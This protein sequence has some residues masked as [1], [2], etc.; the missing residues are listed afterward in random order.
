MKKARWVLLALMLCAL[1]TPG[2]QAVAG[3]NLTAEIGYDGVITYGRSLPLIAV[4]EAGESGIEGFIQVDLYRNGVQYD[5]VEYPIAVAAGAQKRVVLPVTLTMAQDQYEIKLVSG[6]GEALLET[7]F[8]PARALDPNSV[9]LGLLSQQA[10]SLS[11]LNAEA[12]ELT[13]TRGARWQAIPLSEKTFPDRKELL[14]AFNILVVDGFDARTLSE[15]Q[16]EALDGYLRGGGLLLL[17]GGAQAATNYPFFEKYTGIAPGGLKSSDQVMQAL[18]AYAKAG[19]GAQ[20]QA[21]LINQPV[22]NQAPLVSGDAPFLYKNQVDEGSILTF[23]FELGAKPFSTWESAQKALQGAVEAASPEF[24]S[25]AGSGGVSVDPY[26]VSSLLRQIPVPNEQG[27]MAAFWLLLC[28]LLLAGL[29]SYFLLKKLD[30]RGLMWLTVPAL[31]LL[32][33]VALRLMGAKLQLD[34]PVATTLS[35][36]SGDQAGGTAVSSYVGAASKSAQGMVISAEGASVAPDTS[37]ESRWIEYDDQ[38]EPRVPTQLRYRLILGE[39]SAAGFPALAAW[40]VQNARV[41]GV[42]PPASA[43]TGRVWMEEDGL[44][45]QLEN[46]LDAELEGGVLLSTVG[47]ASTGDLAPGAAATASLRLPGEEQAPNPDSKW[48]ENYVDGTMCAAPGTGAMFRRDWYEVVYSAGEASAK[49]SGASDEE[50]SFRRGALAMLSNSFDAASWADSNAFYFAAF[51]DELC[52]PQILVD[53]EAAERTGHRAMLIAPL[54]YE[55]VGPTGVV[56][57]PAGLLP[58]QLAAEETPDDPRA[59]SYAPAAQSTYDINITRVFRFDLSHLGKVDYQAVTLYAYAYDISP[60]L[61]IYDQ[62]TGRWEAQNAGV[63][64]LKSEDIP[65]FVGDGGAVYL[66]VDPPETTD[67]DRFYA[68]MERPVIELMGRV[69]A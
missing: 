27:S 64:N 68:A 59:A 61:S 26:S 43:L 51:S 3:A 60:V 4:V 30:K 48:G 45:A 67:G 37:D 63:I 33:L 65:R 41:E 36:L 15:A 38:S 1:L 28:Y 66:K 40:T 18:S 2:A 9:L 22:A 8:A 13:A 50:R 47:F 39:H 25:A 7:A 54:A 62:Q 56:Y 11:Y 23:A 12:G 14:S 6:G 5:R 42:Q 29:G 20:A 69:N 16:K 34:R 35:I 55:P 58:A 17:G 32:A 53:G 49:S 19:G 57:C 24:F 44:H 52:R 31:A 46:A 21:V 10:N